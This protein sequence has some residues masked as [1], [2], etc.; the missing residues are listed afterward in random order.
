MLDSRHG[1]AVHFVRALGEGFVRD[2]LDASIET[3]EWTVNAYNLAFAVLLLTGAALGE[4]FGRRRM[5][6]AGIALFA[7]ASIA[8]A[9]AGGAAALI[10]ARAVQGAGAALVMP[11]AMALLSTAFAREE[12]GRALGIFAGITGLALVAGPLLGALP[13]SGDLT[14]TPVPGSVQHVYHAG[15]PSGIPSQA[16]PDCVAPDDPR[17]LYAC[18][19]PAARSET[20]RVAW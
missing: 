9:L 16:I 17:V 13:A 1:G 4:R 10:A 6:V 7:A 5:F 20:G 8:C 12:R 18:L 2:D 11:L 19:S 14:G 15:A 3:L